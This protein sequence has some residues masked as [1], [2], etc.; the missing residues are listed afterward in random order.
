MICIL[1]NPPAEKKMATCCTLFSKI[2]HTH[3][4]CMWQ[5]ACRHTALESRRRVFKLGRFWSNHNGF[6][7]I[8]FTLHQYSMSIQ[9]TEYTSIRAA[10]TLGVPAK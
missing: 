4:S 3:T 5:N 7:T 8:G 2:D 10:A 6:N 1:K 9:Y